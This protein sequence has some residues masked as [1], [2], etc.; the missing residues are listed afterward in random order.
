MTKGADDLEA[1]RK[2][3]LALQ[4]FK[5][6]DQERII[7]WAREKL[8]L[9]ARS[10]GPSRTDRAEVLTRTGVPVTS[11]SEG[12]KNIKAFVTAKDPKSDNQFA[13]SVA[14]YYRFEAP[15]ASRKDAISAD[16]LQDAARQAGRRRL[17]D[18]G[19]TLRNAH[20]VGLLDKAGDR[21]EFAINAVGENL[22]AMTLPAGERRRVTAKKRT[23]STGKKAKR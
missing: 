20:A 10:E 17:G 16:D 14:Y 1:V 8:G 12:P 4:G 23:R 15:Q 13:A 19:K 18:P 6:D 7:R 11:E 22:V 3:T 21:G 2:V 5:E 9:V